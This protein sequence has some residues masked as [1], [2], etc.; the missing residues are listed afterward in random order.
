M[1]QQVDPSSSL[2]PQPT[3]YSHTLRLLSGE[4]LQLSQYRDHVILVVNTA[5]RCGLTPQ[6]RQ[7]E[8]LYQKY[9]HRRF[10]II[11]CP[12]NQFGG[13][14]LAT[15]DEVLSFCQRHFKVSFPLTQKLKVNGVRAHPLFM[16]LKREARGLL[17]TQRIKWNF[18]KF[19]ITP[20]A[21]QITRYAPQKTPLELEYEIQRLLEINGY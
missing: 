10:T 7:L 4:E 17:G 14:E 16:E 1:N 12:C 11:G 18:T 6:Y 15:G 9:G 5:S 21:T 13:Q 20:R 3:I 19:L 8:E 2:T